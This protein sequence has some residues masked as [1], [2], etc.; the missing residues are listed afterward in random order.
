MYYNEGI[1]Q[2]KIFF[3]LLKMGQQYP[4]YSLNAFFLINRF[5]SHEKHAMMKIIFLFH[6]ILYFWHQKILKTH[7]E[8]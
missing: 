2:K 7:F 8:I 5:A 3:Y 6:E 1:R 4:S